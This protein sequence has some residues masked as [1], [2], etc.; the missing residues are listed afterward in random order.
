MGISVIAS[1]ITM[2]ANADYPAD[3]IKAVSKAYDEMLKDSKMPSDPVG[4]VTLSALLLKAGDKD[5]AVTN[6]KK[7]AEY[8][9]KK[10]EEGNQVGMKL[11]AEPFA[12]Y[13]KA[14]EDGNPPSVQE[15]YGWLR[16][17]MAGSGAVPAAKIQ[18]KPTKE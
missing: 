13:V 8:V 4:L 11:P 18:V 5:A 1:K 7:A 16:E 6:A 9:S 12:R 10:Q 14:M 17:G 3:L 2:Q 15:F